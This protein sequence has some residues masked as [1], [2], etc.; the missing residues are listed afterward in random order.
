MTTLLSETE[1]NN[2]ASN[3]CDPWHVHGNVSVHNNG[4]IDN[5]V[6]SLKIKLPQV[7]LPLKIGP[8][9]YPYLTCPVDQAPTSG[10]YLDEAHRFNVIING[11]LMFRRYTAG[12]PLMYGKLG[13]SPSNEL[14]EEM[15]HFFLA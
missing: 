9:G 7:E 8:T 13:L 11:Y 2:I 10:W 15:V 1:M 5:F 14:S 4:I 12:G 3:S 6:E